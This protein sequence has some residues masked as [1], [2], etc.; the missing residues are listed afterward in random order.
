MAST[1]D[2]TASGSGLARAG[3][4][5]AST[6]GGGSGTDG[7]GSG[8]DNRGKSDVDDRKGSR[9]VGEGDRSD[10]GKNVRGESHIAITL[11]VIQQLYIPQSVTSLPF[12]F[13]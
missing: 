11:P 1:G 9:T 8:T 12:W 2:G 6:D 7:G 5:I 4:G 3:G 10:G 13:S